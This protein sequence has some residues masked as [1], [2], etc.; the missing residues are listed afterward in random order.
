MFGFGKKRSEVLVSS[1]EEVEE[2]EQREEV[3]GVL[4]AWCLASQGVPAGEGSHGICDYHSHMLL[5][6]AQRRRRR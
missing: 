5:Q 2:V 1:A 3:V 4:C 6:Q